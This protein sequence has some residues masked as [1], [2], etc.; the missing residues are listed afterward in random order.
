MGAGRAG[1]G[2]GG[3]CPGTSGGAGDQRA[4]HVTSPPSHSPPGHV[5]AV[6]C[7]RRAHMTRAPSPADQWAGPPASPPQ[8]TPPPALTAFPTPH[9]LGAPTDRVSPPRE[10]GRARGGGGR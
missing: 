8:H 1:P 6:M 9:V 10:G 7:G 2:S 4:R 5:T 3:G